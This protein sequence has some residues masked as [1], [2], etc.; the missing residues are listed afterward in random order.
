VFTGNT[1]CGVFLLLY[2]LAT[3]FG[4]HHEGVGVGHS[5]E[6][7]EH[8]IWYFAF[9]SS[10]T[11]C[12]VLAFNVL[13]LGPVCTHVWPPGMD[14]RED[15]GGTAETHQTLELG[16]SPAALKGAQAA[17]DD[18]EAEPGSSSSSSGA[19][20]ALPSPVEFVLMVEEGDLIDHKQR[21]VV[22][23]SSLAEVEATLLRELAL[24][25]SVAA[26]SVCVDGEPVAGIAKLPAKS[27]I[28]LLE[29]HGGSDA[30][31]AA[32]AAEL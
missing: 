7:L 16:I 18:G 6:T 26:V 1:L 21:V 32:P 27:R 10:F 19:E 5:H 4:A 20:P 15:A 13:W 23:A 24:S 2:T 22:E 29:R 17:A 28:Q 3:G 30:D 8:C 9:S 14:G 25:R 12:A 31:V 11:L